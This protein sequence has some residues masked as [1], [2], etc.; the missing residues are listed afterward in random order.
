M[1]SLFNYASNKLMK[2]FIMFF[3]DHA[4]PA[5]DGENYLDI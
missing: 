5:L 2:F 1:G 3:S 4:L